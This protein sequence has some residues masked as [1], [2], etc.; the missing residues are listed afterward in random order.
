MISYN[1]NVLQYRTEIDTPVV[2]FQEEIIFFYSKDTRI[3]I[4]LA[5]LYT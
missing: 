3:L 4:F 1:Y 2:F 5:G